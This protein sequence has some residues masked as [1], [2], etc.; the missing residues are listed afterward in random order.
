MVDETEN[1]A[2]DKPVEL[3]RDGRFQTQIIPYD[4][5]VAPCGPIVL[6]YKVRKY[7]RPKSATLETHGPNIRYLEVTINTV[8]YSPLYSGVFIFSFDTT[9]VVR[10][11]GLMDAYRSVPINL[12]L[13]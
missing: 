8:A 10:P 5:R 6:A 13:E 3:V 9:L 1:V 7:K 4:A 12:E 11:G 2:E